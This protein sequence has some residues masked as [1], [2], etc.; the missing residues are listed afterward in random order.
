MELR[1]G[2]GGGPGHGRRWEGVEDGRERA[3]EA[4]F[5]RPP[6]EINITNTQTNVIA[7]TSLIARRK[8]LLLWKS[9]LPPSF[10]MWLSDTMSL[11]K[12][13]KIKFTLRGS[14]DKFYAHWRPLIS[15][16]DRLPPDMVSL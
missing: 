9:P 16:V 5:G 12:L 13:E 3:G 11:L 6:D 8:I 15:Y 2:E 4:I 7:F 1:G 10:K 14:S